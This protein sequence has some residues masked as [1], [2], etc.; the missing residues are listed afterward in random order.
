MTP[1]WYTLPSVWSYALAAIAFAFLA[2]RLLAQWQPGGKPAVLLAFAMLSSAAAA[3]AVAFSITPSL[4]MWWIASGLD[5]LRNGAT[6]AF[7]L[8]FLGVR[9][10]TRGAKRGGPGWALLVSVG[11]LLC[12]AQ[13]LLGVKPPGV[14]NLAQTVHQLGFGNE[15]AI[16][17]FGLVLVEQCYRR[18]PPASR[19]HVRPL[20]LGLGGLLV[21]DLVL[22]SDALLFG[23]LD[24][25]LW[26]A[27]GF[28]QAIA[29]PMML[30]TLRRT[31]DW[32]FDLTISRG[33]LAGSTALLGAGAY[34]V[35]M[36]GAGFLLKELGG[37]WGRALQSALVFAALLLLA[38]VG[39][40]ATFRAKVRVLVAKNFFTYRYDYRAEWL[41]FTTTLTAGGFGQPW[42]A[43]IR[44]LG[45]LVESPG[46]ALWLL[47]VH[48]QYRQVERS[49]LPLVVQTIAA[50]DPLPTFLGRT[51]WVLEISDVMSNATRYGGL[52]LP[53]EI[54]A[55]RDAWLIVPL[56]SDRN[57]T[58]FAVL[59]VPRIAIEL[60]WEVRDLLKTA[61]GQAGSYLAYAQAT[62]ALLEAQKF[63]AFH[64]M[65]TFVVHDLKN[66]IAQLQLLLS[67]VERHRDNP[68]FQRDML[69]TIE[70]VVG[71][72]HGLTLQLRPEASARDRA[73]PVDVGS[74]ARNVA[75]LRSEW[76]SGLTVEAEDGA[77]AWAHEDLLERVIAHLVQNAFEASV[78]RTGVGLRVKRAGEQV[79][80]EVADRGRGMTPEFVR[81]RLFK[82]FQT[83]KETGMGIGAFECQQYV[84]QVGGS[85]EV[86][87]SPEGGTRVRVRLRSVGS[88]MAVEDKEA[89]Q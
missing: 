83:T 59:A 25:D 70:H 15:L 23:V 56:Q 28:A 37:S 4:G 1:F 74:A 53:A 73:R 50:D 69:K 6:L 61:G 11:V 79:L 58:G 80:I 76:G 33:V 77:V 89:A 5:L 57:L 7:L 14:P 40:S 38:T 49:M 60:D 72:M 13:L 47:D 21:F 41:K 54:S 78:E 2:V 45:D 36:A 42:Q 87:S 65:S 20:L 48:G 3:G 12:V 27:R 17:V 43:C 8:I 82:P 46:G 85:I 64:R 9:D 26:A 67:N 84:Q 86:E 31:H 19:W 10:S 55:M 16:A 34:L 35:I 22:F 71:R 66:L 63:D 18:T 30:L 29:V 52:A 51:G 68:E 62:E 88:K 81:E 39:L 24:V 44:A 75:Q 32:S